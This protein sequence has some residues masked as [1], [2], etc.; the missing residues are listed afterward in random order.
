M[1]PFEVGYSVVVFRP[2]QTMMAK[3]GGHRA[4]ARSSY[5]AP[6][7]LGVVL[8]PGVGPRLQAGPGSEGFHV[9]NFTTVRTYIRLLPY[10][11][12][13]PSFLF[14]FHVLTYVRNILFIIVITTPPV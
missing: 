14:L 7:P 10:L 4:L 9:H 3:G 13:S 6:L 5:L 12:F 2:H 11:I 8:P 1:I